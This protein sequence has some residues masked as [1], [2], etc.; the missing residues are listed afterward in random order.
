M[1]LYDLCERDV[2]S[3]S[4]GDNLGSVDDICFDEKTANI[5]H[6]VLY[7]KTKLFGLLGR[8]EDILIP[9][10]DIAKIGSDVVLVSGSEIEGKR[11]RFSLFKMK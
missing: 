9:W 5:T 6:I 8:E 4:N 2:V 11:K 10:T 3:L 7:G 1:N